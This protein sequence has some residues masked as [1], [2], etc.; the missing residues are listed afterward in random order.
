MSKKLND[1]KLSDLIDIVRSEL[2]ESQEKLQRSQDKT[3]F[4][5]GKVII[6]S[7]F[8]ITESKKGQGG[9]ELGL[10]APCLVKGS[11]NIKG[12]IGKEN[13]S[14]NKIIIELHPYKENKDNDDSP[15]IYKLNEK[16]ELILTSPSGK[17][18]YV[19]ATVPKDICVSTP[20]PKEDTS[21][22]D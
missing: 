16:G 14:S 1:F 7:N 12:E 11:G 4:A 8:T 13:E 2:N 22:F 17:N 6:E 10:S 19:C 15:T 21:L 5:V 18:I 20:A 3:K 9:V